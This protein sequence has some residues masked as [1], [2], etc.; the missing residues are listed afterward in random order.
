MN[1]T[2]KPFEKL[3]KPLSQGRYPTENQVSD[4]SSPTHLGVAQAP[5]AQ[6]Q[7]VVERLHLCVVNGIPPESFS[8]P[9]R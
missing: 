1:P 9:M 6:L 7:G 2:G 5:T 8:E 4:S 3:A